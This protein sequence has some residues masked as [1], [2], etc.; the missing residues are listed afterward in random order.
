MT[1][2]F[3]VLVV[4]VGACG[5]IFL[6]AREKVATGRLGL[7]EAAMSRLVWDAATK[8]QHQGFVGADDEEQQPAADSGLFWAT[9]AADQSARQEPK[10]VAGDF[11][12]VALRN[13]LSPPWTN[14]GAWITYSI[15]RTRW[16]GL[17]CPGLAMLGV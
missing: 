10:V 13:V 1:R 14:S 17:C 2:I 6:T 4:L 7:A 9:G 15:F 12:Q 16:S 3:I 11:D 5:P 8:N